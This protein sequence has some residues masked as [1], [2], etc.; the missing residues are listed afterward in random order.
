MKKHM[1]ERGLV[2]RLH[3]KFVVYLLD[4]TTSK[5]TPTVCYVSLV[6]I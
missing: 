3:I 4:I 6:S 5:A 2:P 1:V